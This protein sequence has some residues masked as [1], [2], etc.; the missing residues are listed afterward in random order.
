MYC[1]VEGQ[2]KNLAVTI[3]AP[4]TCSGNADDRVDRDVQKIVVDGNFQGDFANDTGLGFHPAI[5]GDLV[6]ALG[7]FLGIAYRVSRDTNPGKRFGQCAQ[8][9]WLNY[10]DDDLHWPIKRSYLARLV[11]QIITEINAMDDPK[12][13]SLLAA[14]YPAWISANAVIRSLGNAGG[15]SGA[16]FWRIESGGS[17]YVLRRWPESA[18]GSMSRIRWSHDV[19]REANNNGCQFVPVPLTASNGESLFFHDPALWQ[20]EPWMPGTAD[21]EKNPTSLRLHNVIR[22]LA[23]FHRSVRHIEPGKGAPASIAGRI[24]RL[25]FWYVDGRFTDAFRDLQ[26]Q[27]ANHPSLSNIGESICKQFHHVA[28]PVLE[29]LAG[30]RNTSVGTQPVIG[31]VWHDHILLTGD[32]VTGIVDYGAMK[33]GSISLD[34]GRLVGS[35]VEDDQVG[36]N[37][38][39]DAYRSICPLSEAEFLMAKTLD[40]SGTMLASLNWLSWICVENRQ[41]GPADVVFNRI[42]RIGLRMETMAQKL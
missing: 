25:R 29:N 40:Q 12:I 23:A 9:S 28:K 3:V 16:R 33:L 21:F 32:D 11:R 34:F 17:S 19:L 27:V 30:I 26:N 15:F 22:A 6:F 36:W 14:F 13:R 10:G 37:A 1:F 31:D 35:L 8:A 39:V 24:E 4:M 18:T 42:Q 2:N 41:F 38:A 20:L 5:N 7:E